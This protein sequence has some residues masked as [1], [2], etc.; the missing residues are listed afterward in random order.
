MTIHKHKN[1]PAL[2]YAI[3][4]LLVSFKHSIVS[5]KRTLSVFTTDSLKQR[6]IT[7]SEQLINAVNNLLIIYP[8][9]NKRHLHKINYIAGSYV[10]ANIN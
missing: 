4:G 10:D 1:N 3:R 6:L 8:S 7:I 2:Q 9:T 5:G